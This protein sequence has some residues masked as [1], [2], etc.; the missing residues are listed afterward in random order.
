MISQALVVS[1]GREL[2]LRVT[3][4]A[5]QPC[6]KHYTLIIIQNALVD[7]LPTSHR[8]LAESRLSPVLSNLTLA[9]PIPREH[10]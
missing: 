10:I 5:A 6:R 9:Y 8:T 3:I 2:T 4:G 1:R 7:A